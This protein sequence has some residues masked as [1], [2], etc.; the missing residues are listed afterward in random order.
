MT[1]Q[2]EAKRK[3]PWWG[4]VGWGVAALFAAFAVMAGGFDSTGQMLI[5]LAG[6]IVGVAALI[7]RGR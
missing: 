6:V 5:P 2:S 7:V 1:E 4:Y 3:M